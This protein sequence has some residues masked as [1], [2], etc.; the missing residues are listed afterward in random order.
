M[1]LRVINQKDKSEH[2]IQFDEPAYDAAVN[3]NPDFNTNILRFSYQSL[4]TPPSI[5]DYNMDA[6]TRELKKQQEILGGY[7]KEDYATER[8]FATARDGVKVPVSIV[9][10]KDFKKDSSNPLL[11]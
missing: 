5:Y 7:K 2:Y 6:K 3:I 10:K 8:I 11:L 4:V 1:N 9:Y